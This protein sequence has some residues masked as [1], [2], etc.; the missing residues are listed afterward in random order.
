MTKAIYS[1]SGL[2]DAVEIV[3]SGPVNVVGRNAPFPVT[4]KNTGPYS[5]SAVIEL[6]ASSPRLSTKN[7]TV[8]DLPSKGTAS[9]QIPVEAVGTGQVNVTVVAR[10]L[11]GTTLDVSTPISVRVRADWEGPGIWVVGGVLGA[12]FLAGL[13][14]TIVKG[15]RRMHSDAGQE[16]S[17]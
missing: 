1:L 17:A 2:T 15:R 12:A 16:T 7:E 4:V 10:T 14:R 11:G 8:V 5:L 6:E 13:V 9:T 3:P